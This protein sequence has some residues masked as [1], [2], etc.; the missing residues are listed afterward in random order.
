MNSLEQDLL[1]IRGS[2]LFDAKWYLHAYPDV[3]MSG[4]DPAEHY[5]RFGALLGRNP[6]P[7]FDTVRYTSENPE[8]RSAGINPL[9]H[10]LNGVFSG[11][12]TRG[13]GNPAEFAGSLEVVNSHG[14]VGWA[15]DKARP[16]KAV[17][18]SVF[19]DGTH[20][21]DCTTDMLRPDLMS[22]GMDG[23][24]AGFALS[25]PSAV[26]S[27]GVEVD[28]RFRR[29]GH[30]LK[31][32]PQS[33]LYGS[34]EKNH[35]EG[36]LAR[37]R[38]GK[39]RLITVIVPVFN[40]L[41]AVRECL[42]AL[43]KHL[44]G[45]ASA[46][47][48]NDASTDPLIAPM[49]REFAAGCERIRVE[50]NAVNLG[51]T[52]TINKA[53]A[54]AGSDDIVLLNSDTVVTTRWLDALRYC[55][56][57]S[58]RVA[59][60]T[61]LS[62][63]AGA[64]S[65]PAMG[66]HNPCPDHLDGE[67]L[68][69]AIVHS[70]PGQPI[71]VPT[72]NGFCMLVRR[73]ALD[74][75]GGFDEK[76]YPRGYGEENDFCMRALRAG[77]KNV[78]SDKA[79]VLHKRSQSFQ[80]EKAGL[81]KAGRTQLDIDY[82]EYGQ[83]IGRF[84]D[85]QFNQL[86]K[87]IADSL[88]ATA[89]NPRPRAMYVISTQTGGTPQTN[90]DL[91]RAM[92]GDYDCWLLR[93]D[94]KTITLSQLVDGELEVREVHHL[95][96]VVEPITHVSDDYDSVVAGILYRKAITILHVR[97]V[98]WH[99]L[100]LAKIA[101]S[102]NIPV[103]YS[104]H[105]FY[106]IC[107]SL[108]LLDGDLRYCGGVCTQGGSSCTASLWPSANMPELKHRFVKRWREMVGAFM[109]D[110]DAFITTV[111]TAAKTIEAAYPQLEGRVTVI[112]HGRDFESSGAY[113]RLDR[114]RSKTK[115]LIPGNIGASKGSELIR[116]LAEIGAE[117]RFEFHFLGATAGTLK[118]VGIHHGTYTRDNFHREVRKIGPAFG[119]V[120]SIWAETYCHTL[121]EMWS[122]G[123]PVLGMDIGAVG[124]R[125]RASGAGWLI[126]PTASPEEVL[127]SLDRIVADAEGYQQRLDAV[128]RWQQSEA[129]WNDIE[130]M[131]AQYR[132]VYDSVL[133][134]PE[135]SGARVG[136]L[137]KQRPFIPPTAHIRVIRPW[138]KAVGRSPVNDVRP[139]SAAWLMAGG[140]DHIDAVVIQRD[141]VPQDKVGMLVDF[142]RE[143]RVPYIYEID[144]PLWDLPRAHPDYDEYAA[145]A[146][147][148]RDLIQG[149][150]VV[151]T[152]T[153]ALAE[154][155]RALNPRVEIVETM[156]DTPAWT[157]PLPD[158]APERVLGDAGLVGMDRPRILYMGTK[159]H[160]E[161]LKEV[162]PAVQAVLDARPDAEFIQVGAGDPLPG[163]TFVV[164]PEY[165]ASYPRF[166]QWFRALC[167]G[168]TIAIAPLGDSEFNT[169]KSDI[170]VLDYAMAGVPAIY[171]ACGP[172]R[173]AISHEKTGL[174]VEPDHTAWVFE[175]SR[176]LDDAALRDTLRANA[177]RW[178]SGESRRREQ[179]FR[180]FVA[181]FL[182][183][184]MESPRSMTR[185]PV[186]TTG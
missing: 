48:V 184:R 21:M 113:A 138:R 65:V 180:A 104:L 29:S 64:F 137:Y 182:S 43:M 143:K 36:V 11:V 160:S 46:I 44:P 20:V 14:L 79:Y 164:V 8:L 80:E 107:P 110:C 114:A 18:L 158:G 159:S 134:Q 55:A 169:A 162:L 57:A 133:G 13:V 86:R 150:E 154:Q 105:D 83:V 23:T 63:N 97:H 72:G 144:D 12:P 181:G 25:C 52:R 103:V 118:G 16:G 146:Q 60:V 27:K 102:Q 6:G 140:G 62:N 156:L 38:D 88:S 153:Q 186:A 149:A 58:P 152:S 68:A 41:E 93:C 5:L 7:S 67:G 47:V 56:Y 142:L 78:V 26:F 108:N 126:E 91:M 168:C 167:R 74:V 125:I 90:L 161:D 96:Q 163:A 166:V 1:L 128:C 127:A 28:V 24:V 155:L 71:E 59:T 2:S 139:V 172:Y 32:S 132:K 170:K 50:T 61:A 123:V 94:S 117:Q 119:V 19:V 157:V 76:R 4:I 35:G 10:H 17:E 173:S 82:P 73:E 136:L 69:R 81:I 179:A 135:R 120:F 183:K 84:R 165:A 147:Q 34:T 111:P 129:V 175:M 101:R 42:T 115:I 98:A 22:H 174:L 116:K 92:S 112:P 30:S 53:I 141:A 131:A 31:R 77:W 130:T 70:T 66:K 40:A 171:S 51:Y 99:S 122:C 87:R 75:L 15:V 45:Y 121:T 100:N 176:L 39:F 124:D 178:A 54:L 3:A 89:D 145:H 85:L 49:L 185:T 148:L 95:S 37:Y 9:V 106:S 33:V 177:L 109:A 151:T